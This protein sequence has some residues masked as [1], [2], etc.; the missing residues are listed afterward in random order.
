MVHPFLHLVH[1]IYLNLNLLVSRQT[2]QNLVEWEGGTLDVV[3]THLV[4]DLCG[5]F[6]AD[7]PSWAAQMCPSM[8]LEMFAHEESMVARARCFKETAAEEGG[9]ALS[10]QDFFHLRE[11]MGVFDNLQT[12]K[13]TERTQEHLSTLE[14]VLH[15][16]NSSVLEL[17][18]GIGEHTEWLLSRGCSVLAS[19][20]RM[21]NVRFLQRWLGKC[22]WRRDEI[23]EPRNV[24][25]TATAVLD[26]EN[27]P[28]HFHD[29]DMIYAS[30]ILYHVSNPQ[31][32]LEW[33]SRHT[34]STL[35]L[36]TC[37]ALQNT[38]VPVMYGYDEDTGALNQATVS[39][40]RPTLAWIIMTLK[41]NFEAVYMPVNTF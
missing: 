3:A 39:G 32:V 8:L 11:L 23:H 1:G 35:I 37:V 28:D 13:L 36:S 10:H 31:R 12:R 40:S 25:K 38:H 20:A 30:G 5:T 24:A 7:F 27:L 17:G 14:H 26:L 21:A 19:D 29:F 15:I 16:S 18:A 22:P 6:K 9:A 33:G 4:A 2:T 34:K 41:Q